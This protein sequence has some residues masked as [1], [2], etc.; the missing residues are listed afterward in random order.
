MTCT[1]RLLGRARQR[2]VPPV[3]YGVRR[4]LAVEDADE[5]EE[6]LPLVTCTHRAVKS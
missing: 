3:R 6:T 1:L 2:L 4:P 5:A